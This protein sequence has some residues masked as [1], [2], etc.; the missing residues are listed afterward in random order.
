VGAAI[1]D[2]LGSDASTSCGYFRNAQD[3]IETRFQ[4]RYT[5]AVTL[6]EAPL[7]TDVSIQEVRGE[8]GFRRRL[9]ELG[10]LPGKRVRVLRVAPLGDPLQLEASGTQLSIRARE[11]AQITVQLTSEAQAPVAAQRGE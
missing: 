3:E 7:G 2:A 6:A 5:W 8:R 10:L 4:I 11:A 9:L 1:C